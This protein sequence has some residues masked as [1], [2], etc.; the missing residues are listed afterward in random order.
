[1]KRTLGTQ[2]RH[3]IELLDGAVARSYEQIGL[4]YRPRYTPIMRVL[5]DQKSCT[6]GDIAIAAKVTQPAAT[7]T[8]AL[9]LKDGIVRADSGISDGRQKMISLT[10]QGQAMV[11]ELL[12]CWS[13]TELAAQSIEDELPHSFTESLELAI[14]V[15]E[16]KSFD[17]RIQEARLTVSPTRKK[18]KNLKD[19]INE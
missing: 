19:D 14:D 18:T 1:M 13:V 10:E 15:L 11:P 2:L 12:R 8:I 6:I 17:V 4:N 9:M 3:L 16:A 7:Q 5:I